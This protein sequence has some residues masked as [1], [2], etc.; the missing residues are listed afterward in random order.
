LRWG[1][2]R[3]K[4]LETPMNADITPMNAEEDREQ[5]RFE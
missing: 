1:Y 5:G 4:S 2:D 3:R